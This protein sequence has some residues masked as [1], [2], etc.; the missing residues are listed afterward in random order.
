MK[1]TFDEILTTA[2]TLPA[3]LRVS[4]AEELL[5]GISPTERQQLMEVNPAW[6]AELKRRL[7]EFRDDP[8]IALDGEKVMRELEEEFSAR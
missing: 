3:D 4:L 6:E 1:A 7:Q 2:R 5:G 8:S